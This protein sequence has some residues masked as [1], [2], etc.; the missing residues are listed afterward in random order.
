MAARAADLLD[1][2]SLSCSVAAAADAT[3]GSSSSAASSSSLSS[4]A[5]PRNFANLNDNSS[6]TS[7]KS[8]PFFFLPDFFFLGLFSFS[9]AGSAF[10]TLLPFFRIASRLFCISPIT[11]CH[12]P[13]VAGSS[14]F[15]LLLLITNFTACLSVG[16]GG[17][18]VPEAQLG[19]GGATNPGL[20]ASPSS[21]SVTSTSSYSSIMGPATGS[22]ATSMRAVYLP[23]WKAGGATGSK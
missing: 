14:T 13:A 23:S 2:T 22:P 11:A 3:D 20:A 17:P 9:T 19:R 1:L 21:S 7:L 5:S 16:L 8:F 18:P 4:S 12:P 15:F 10:G 6:I